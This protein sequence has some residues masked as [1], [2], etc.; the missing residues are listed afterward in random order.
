MCDLILKY[1]ALAKLDSC[2]CKKIMNKYVIIF[3]DLNWI[4][5]TIDTIRDFIFFSSYVSK[6]VTQTRINTSQGSEQLTQCL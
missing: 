6:R 5:R 3:H 1:S 4:P 2:Y